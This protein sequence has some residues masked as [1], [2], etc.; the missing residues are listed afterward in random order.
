MI[1]RSAW[2]STQRLFA[3]YSQELGTLRF[4]LGLPEK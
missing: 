3:V 1:R 2:W 4:F